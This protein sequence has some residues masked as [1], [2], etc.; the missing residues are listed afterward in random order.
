MA[1]LKQLLFRAEST[2]KTVILV[3]EWVPDVFLACDCIF[4]R[5]QFFAV[6]AAAVF[7]AEVSCAV[8]AVLDG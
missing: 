1:E 5:S 4:S 3:I 7:L 6:V 8:G 2:R